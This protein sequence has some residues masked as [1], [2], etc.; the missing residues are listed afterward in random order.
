MP[1]D[2]STVL[3]TGAT[4]FV[5]SHVVR[6]LTTA[7]V[8]V[9]ATSRDGNHRRLA[10][11]QGAAAI[12]TLDLT[13]AQ[14]TARVLG[15]C[16]P[17]LIVH[18]AAY[19]V[20]PR[21]QD[22]TQAFAVNVEASMRL[23]EC[24]AQLGVR[25]FVYLG[26]CFEYGSK[27]HPIKEDES[28]Q[29]IGMYAV[30]KAAASLLLKQLA[31]DLGL[32]L[33]VVRPFG[34][35]GPFE[36]DHRLAPQ[37]VRACVSRQPLDLTACEQVR[38]YTYVVDIAHAIKRLSLMERFPAGAVVNLGSRSVLLK[39][40]VLS[41]AR[42]LDGEPLMRFGALPY[43]P[44]EMSRLVADRSEYHRLVGDMTTTPIDKGVHAMVAAL[45]Q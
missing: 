19:G 32:P 37:V 7:G 38:D 10:D 5:G 33:I 30:T 39:E 3:V 12:V 14:Q 41:L 31:Q 4:G 16:T 40:F 18:C 34:I 45:A 44:N 36:G 1:A 8:S 17:D 43:R 24:A 13:D 26:S 9:V 35:W 28:L 20:D 42:V 22:P 11:L 21:Q 29:P 25:R 23:V 15:R 27:D 2:V 6:A